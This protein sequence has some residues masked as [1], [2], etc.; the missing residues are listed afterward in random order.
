MNADDLDQRLAL[1]HR[2]ALQEAERLEQK[3]PPG[4]KYSRTRKSQASA[5]TA[6]R[7][8]NA[9]RDTCLRCAVELRALNGL[10]PLPEQ[11]AQIR[12]GRIQKYGLTLAQYEGL[13]EE[14]DGACLICAFKPELPDDL[15]I[16]HNHDTGEVR[17]LLCR[18]CN[19][20]LGVF[21][22]SPALLDAAAAYLDERG[23][24]G[25]AMEDR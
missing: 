2:F 1:I 11:L 16:D 18:A 6:C 21:Q 24:Y 14:Q 17:G 5:R 8:C 23:H 19:H 7:A 12:R 3:P 20:G 15:N 25:S 4:V 9:K 10:P 22:D 13:I